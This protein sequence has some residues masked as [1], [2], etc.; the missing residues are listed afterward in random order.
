MVDIDSY[1]ECKHISYLKYSPL[2]S[3]SRLSLMKN[4]LFVSYM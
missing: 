1:L 2:C 4:P 3:T